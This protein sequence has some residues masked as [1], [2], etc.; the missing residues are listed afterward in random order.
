MTTYIY[1]I[2]AS[3]YLM[4][5]GIKGQRWGVRR[6]QDMAGSLTEE[7][8]K[9]YGYTKKLAK[10][11]VALGKAK[12]EHYGVRAADKAGDVKRAAYNLGVKARRMYNPY[13]YKNKSNHAV[14]DYYYKK[15]ANRAHVNSA[16]IQA[17][18]ARKRGAEFLDN[19]E[20]GLLDMA[21]TQSTVDSYGRH[22][23]RSNSYGTNLLDISSMSINELRSASGSVPNSIADYGKRYLEAED[24]R[25]ALDNITWRDYFEPADVT[26]YA[27][28]YDTRKNLTSQPS[29]MRYYD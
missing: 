23:T 27:I 9:R 20:Q 3:P 7:G 4:H 25:K 16:T 22:S 17:E 18:A 21:G 8:R 2:D 15:S 1:A 26:E 10:F 24:R 19:Y 5:H 6:F 11:G 13:Y 29:W 28:R 14:W 12:A